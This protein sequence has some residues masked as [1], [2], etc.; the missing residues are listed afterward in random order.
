M[1]YVLTDVTGKRIGAPMADRE[2]L[3]RAGK[4]HVLNKGGTVTAW[5]ANDRGEVIGWSAADTAAIRRAVIRERG[6]LPNAAI[7]EA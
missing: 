1:K 7:A 4:A 2:E 6:S 3:L 5:L